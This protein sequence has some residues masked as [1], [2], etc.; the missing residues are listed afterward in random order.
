MGT[1]LGLFLAAC[2]LLVSVTGNVRAETNGSS[3]L[4]GFSL[5]EIRGADHENGITLDIL[6]CEYASGDLI[7]RCEVVLPSEE[8]APPHPTIVLCHGGINGVTDRGRIRA[9]RLA[10]EGYLVVMPSYRGEDGSDGEIEVAAGEVDDVL[11]CV[12]LLRGCA[13]VDTDKLAVIGTSHG[14]L[15][16]ALAATHDSELP[17][18]VCAYGVMDIVGWWYYLQD[19]EQ[20][21]EDD[22]SRRIYGGGPLDHLEEFAMRSVIRVACEIEPPVFIL[23]GD[24]DTLVPLEQAQAL[25]SA[26]AACGKANYIYTVYPDVGHGFILWHDGDRDRHGDESLQTAERAW[27]DIL[28]FIDSCWEGDFAGS[29]E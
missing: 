21:E 4:P 26:F 3:P 8:Y 5:L 1:N 19:S 22:L 20:Y 14:A 27:D 13:V 28:E 24:A 7:V 9:F 10:R 12:D 25:D 2:L 16:A 18:V 6:R 29:S 23:Q 11:A 17:A 15:I